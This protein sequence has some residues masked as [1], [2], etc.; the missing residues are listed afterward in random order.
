MTK[1]SVEVERSFLDRL[2]QTTGFSLEY[3][4]REI[5]DNGPAGQTEIVDWLKSKHGFRQIDAALLSGIYLNDG[6]PVYCEKIN[7]ITGEVS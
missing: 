6:R 3:W 1:S 4:A 5:K 2:E 7:C